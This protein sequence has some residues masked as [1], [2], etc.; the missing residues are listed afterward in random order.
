VAKILPSPFLSGWFAYRRFV[1]GLIEMPVVHRLHNTEQ[2]GIQIDI[3]AKR[4]QLSNPQASQHEQQCDRACRLIQSR[5]EVFR[6]WPESVQFARSML[7]SREFRLLSYV[8]VDTAP[9]F[10]ALR[11]C[12]DHI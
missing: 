6:T 10:A 2:L 7:S 12:S 5:S 9:L 4:E 3:P 11:I 1:C 8:L